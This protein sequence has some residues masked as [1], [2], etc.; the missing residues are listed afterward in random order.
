M[1]DRLQNYKSHQ[2]RILERE[3]RECKE[4]NFLRNNRGNSPQTEEMMSAETG[5][6]LQEINLIREQ[7]LQSPQ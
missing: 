1:E 3:S 4:S 7:H 6:A 5:K 2:I